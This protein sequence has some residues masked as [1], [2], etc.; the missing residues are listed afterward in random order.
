M[1]EDNIHILCVEIRRDNQIPPYIADDVIHDYIK[2]GEAELSNMVNDV[3]FETDIVARSILKTYV[4]YA[5]HKMLDEFY[6]NHA[7]RLLSW[8]LS[9]PVK[10]EK[11]TD[12][13]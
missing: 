12:I 4:L 6:V 1:T 9:H 5:H 2:D 10:D 11:A 7:S 13:P 3:D 8:Q